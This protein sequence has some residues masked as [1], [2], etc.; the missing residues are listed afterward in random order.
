M[1]FKAHFLHLSRIDGTFCEL[2]QLAAAFLSW[3]QRPGRGRSCAEDSRSSPLTVRGE[4]PSRAAVL[5]TMALFIMILG[6][7]DHRFPAQCVHVC[8]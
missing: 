5:F 2:A 6:V 3:V 1:Y 8:S 7:Q 4:C